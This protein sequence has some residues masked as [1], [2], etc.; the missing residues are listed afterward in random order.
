MTPEEYQE[1][2]KLIMVGIDSRN[3]GKH[4]PG[5]YYNIFGAV[6]RLD[7]HFEEI[8]KAKQTVVGPV[9]L[10]PTSMPPLDPAP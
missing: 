8:A 4:G 6:L 1:V 2:R 9:R 10:A 5:D 3:D 7:Q